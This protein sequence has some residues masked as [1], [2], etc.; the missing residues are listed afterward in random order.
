MAALSLGSAVVL[1]TVANDETERGNKGTL[2]A[3]AKRRVEK[4]LLDA[5]RAFFTPS[6]GTWVIIIAGKS[7]RLCQLK[8][9]GT[10]KEQTKA[11]F[12]ADFSDL[13]WNQNLHSIT[14]H[15][16]TCSSL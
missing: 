14:A 10:Y 1:Q 15:D 6:N 3:E 16:L 4:K 2:N 9:A 7:L 12:M 13:I 11:A 5:T 8:I